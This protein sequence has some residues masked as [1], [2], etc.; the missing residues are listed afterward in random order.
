[1]IIYG[2]LLKK[3]WYIENYSKENLFDTLFT[4]RISVKN[5]IFEIN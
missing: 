2:Y 4:G 3:F 5:H 1:M